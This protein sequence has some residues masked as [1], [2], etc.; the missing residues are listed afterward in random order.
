MSTGQTIFPT[1]STANEE[2]TAAAGKSYITTLR[3]QALAQWWGNFVPIDQ[4]T[5]PA[6]KP[7]FKGQRFQRYD[8]SLETRLETLDSNFGDSEPGTYEKHFAGVTEVI[9]ELS[10][11]AT[12]VNPTT[13]PPLPAPLCPTGSRIRCSARTPAQFQHDFIVAASQE[14]STPSKSSAVKQATALAAGTT[15]MKCHRNVEVFSSHAKIF[16]DPEVKVFSPPLIGIG[17]NTDAV[18]DRF[19][20]GD[21]TILKLRELITTMRSSRWEA[22]L[23]SPK[24]DSTYEQASNLMAALHADLNGHQMD[25]MHKISSLLLVVLK[26]PLYFLDRS[27]V[28]FVPTVLKLNIY[29]NTLSIKLLFNGY[30]RP[31][32]ATNSTKGPPQQGRKGSSYNSMSPEVSGF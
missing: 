20:M 23:R 30:F 13:S 25:G 4:W 18:I 21:Q 1:P 11:P 31:T 7:M 26:S 6:V 29:F 3:Q 9:E 14:S 17:P 12:P 19:K 27:P 5:P 15:K 2:L 32:L 22:I 8:M 10:V 28:I 16:G 24:W